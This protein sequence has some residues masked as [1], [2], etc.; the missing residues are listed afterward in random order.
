MT[1]VLIGFE[2]KEIG[3]D[4]VGVQKLLANAYHLYLW[5]KHGLIA[6]IGDNKTGA[7]SVAAR[8]FSMSEAH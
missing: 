8:P 6:W 5:P 1:T 3:V 2:L 7:T 4:G